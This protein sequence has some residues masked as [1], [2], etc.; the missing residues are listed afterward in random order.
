MALI[1]P[2]NGDLKKLLKSAQKK[3]PQSARLS[4]GGGGAKAKRAMPKCLRH[5]FQWGFPYSLKVKACL[6]RTCQ[7]PFSSSFLQVPGQSGV[8]GQS[9]TPLGPM[10]RSSGL[11]IV[12]M[13]PWLLPV[14]ATQLK[15]L[16]AQQVTH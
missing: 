14:M 8:I 13:L 4:A 6:A 2:Q 16:H 1:Y 12:P 10:V 7:F 15:R 5:E 3:V 11:A 9:V